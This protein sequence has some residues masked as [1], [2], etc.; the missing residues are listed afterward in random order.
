MIQSH[1]ALSPTLLSSLIET[2][3]SILEESEVGDGVL[4]SGSQDR[5]DISR[6]RSETPIPEQG[7]N[8]KRKRGGVKFEKL[9]G[10]LEKVVKMQEENDAASRKRRR[11]YWKWK[12]DAI[13]RI[14]SSSCK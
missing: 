7:N 4:G 8:R 6:S 9:E 5:D 2:V 13:E 12:D 3:D 14:G 10:F 11:S 1:S